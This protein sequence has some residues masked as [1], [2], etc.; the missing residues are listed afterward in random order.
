MNREKLK[1]RTHIPMA[2]VLI[3]MLVLTVAGYNHHLNSRI[4]DEAGRLSRYIDRVFKRLVDHDAEIIELHFPFLAEN[5]PL[6]SAFTAGRRE[7]LLRYAAPVYQEILKKVQVSHLNFIDRNGLIV[8]SVHDPSRNGDVLESIALEEAKKTGDIVHGV[9]PG[10]PGGFTLRVVYPWTLN[11]AVA[12][13]IEMGKE[14]SLV[15]PLIAEMFDIKIF[16]LMEKKCLRRQ[17]WEQNQRNTGLDG[18]WDRFNNYIMTDEALTAPEGLDI[19]I[20]GILPG[21]TGHSVFERS[22]SDKIY[23][24]M[25]FPIHGP[26]NKTTG[27]FLM[28]D[29]IS[30]TSKSLRGTMVI[31]IAGSVIIGIF[32]LGFFWRYVGRVEN[33]IETARDQLY[34]EAEEH[35]KAVHRFHESEK[36]IHN[37]LNRLTLGVFECDQN[38]IINYANSAMGTITDYSVEELMGKN[39]LDLIADEEKK[40]ALEDYLK[41][42]IINR[43]I[44]APYIT[45]IK[46]RNGSKIDIKVDWNYRHNE[47]GRINGLACVISDITA[48]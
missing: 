18:K 42:L 37:I 28:M 20:N 46:K 31:V 36:D 29:D 5:R 23:M 39:L 19:I 17:Q 41:S 7:L 6:C 32:I 3:V 26:D 1:I 21:K 45:G 48:K 33:R 25:T 14:M 13:Y 8:L 27:F 40:A 9:E 34:T 16:T 10:P 4:F 22:F 24:I 12:G 43:P 44:P 15:T 47:F 2:L 11:G 35:K 38:G 30:R